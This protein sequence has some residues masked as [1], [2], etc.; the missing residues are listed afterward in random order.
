MLNLYIDV[1]RVK[2]YMWHAIL[3]PRGLKHGQC[4]LP[5]QQLKPY[6]LVYA[7]E[8]V[9]FASLHLLWGLQNYTNNTIIV[10]MESP[11]DRSKGRR[12]LETDLT[13]GKYISCTN[14]IAAPKM[15]IPS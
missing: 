15:N 13:F 3:D 10:N 12:R 1:S 14:E 6:E 9:I 8:D 7:L 2:I 4:Q 11:I 5:R